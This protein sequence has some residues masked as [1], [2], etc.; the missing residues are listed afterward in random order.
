[1]KLKTKKI[2]RRV[3]YTE[4]SVAIQ[5]IEE[6]NFG[7]AK[8]IINQVLSRVEEYDLPKTNENQNL[9]KV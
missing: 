2:S 7:S 5:W 3:L 6:M 8:K 9:P 1:M 4:L